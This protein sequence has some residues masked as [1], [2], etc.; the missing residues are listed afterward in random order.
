MTDTLKD[1]NVK[2][3]I[4]IYSNNHDFEINN[5]DY[6]ETV[7]VLLCLLYGCDEV[8]VGVDELVKALTLR[9]KNAFEVNNSKVDLKSMVGVIVWVLPMH[10]KNIVDVSDDDYTTKSNLRLEFANNVLSA[11]PKIKEKLSHNTLPL[12]YERFINAVSKP[13]Q[14]ND[15]KLNISYDKVLQIV[16]KFFY[17]FKQ[18][19]L[20]N[21]KS[22]FEIM[23]DQ[24]I[25][26]NRKYN[27]LNANEFVSFVLE[28][29]INTMNA[30]ADYLTDK[31]QDKSKNEMQ[32]E[33]KRK[34]RGESIPK[35][36]FESKREELNESKRDKYLKILDEYLKIIND[37][38]SK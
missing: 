14:S 1:S 3:A 31:P 23:F 16:L 21:Y 8:N 29:L 7:A 38:N 18:K 6:I 12:A 27:N 4:E 24:T 5:S 10:S 17:I 28:G 33:L 2:I 15:V 19:K 34:V 11:I 36:Y 9:V 22:A 26:N 37:D 35:T 25:Y 30:L 20:E 13:D 32:D